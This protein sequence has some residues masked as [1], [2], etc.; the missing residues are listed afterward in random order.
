MYKPSSSHRPDAAER[1]RAPSECPV[2]SSTDVATA[3]KTVTAES[4]WRCAA[5]GEVWNAGRRNG[6]A[7]TGVRHWSR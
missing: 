4:Y 3:S 2:C 7:A 6:A 5:C 1:P